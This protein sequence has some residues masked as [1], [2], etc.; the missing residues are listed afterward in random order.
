MAGMKRHD[1]DR[2]QLIKESEAFVDSGESLDEVEAH[3]S[4]DG[5]CTSKLFRTPEIQELSESGD[6]ADARGNELNTLTVVLCLWS[7]S[8]RTQNQRLVHQMK[9]VTSAL[10]LNQM[11]R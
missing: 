2:I 6:A 8:S 7:T 10:Q 5:S 3:F 9:M 4:I 1:F 11:K